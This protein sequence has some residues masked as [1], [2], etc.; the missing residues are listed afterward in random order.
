M[1]TFPWLSGLWHY[2]CKL[3][4]SSSQGS[5]FTMI[6]ISAYRFLAILLTAAFASSPVTSDS[7]ASG[8][9]GGMRDMWAGMALVLIGTA[10]SIA[11]E[12]RSARTK[13]SS[14]VSTPQVAVGTSNNNDVPPPL[15]LKN[16]NTRS[17]KSVL[18]IPSDSLTQQLRFELDDFKKQPN[19]ISSVDDQQTA[20][21]S[22]SNASEVASSPP[23]SPPRSTPR[24]R[25]Q[26]ASLRSS[27]FFASPMNA[28][29]SSGLAVA[30]G[31]G[32]Q[33]NKAKLP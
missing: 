32:E 11:A 17:P 9:G 31:G 2:R 29:L 23:R 5:L 1:I 26:V 16:G 27:A 18:Q 14:E 6:A 13:T 10:A 19:V 3:T 7:E 24:R 20:A 15:I 33:Q 12:T 25:Q 30:F 21:A 4:A 28:L 8:P 22:H